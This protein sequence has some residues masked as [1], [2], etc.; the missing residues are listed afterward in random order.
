MIRNAPGQEIGVALLDV[1]GGYHCG[2][3]NV[4]VTVKKR[5]LAPESGQGALEMLHYGQFIY[6][7]TAGETDTDY[8]AVFFHGGKLIPQCVQC[9]TAPGTVEPP[10]AIGGKASISRVE[11]L[12]ITASE[13][14]FGS[15]GAWLSGLLQHDPIPLTPKIL[16]GLNRAYPRLFKLI[17][18]AP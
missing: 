4:L 9:Q 2:Q 7:P 14:V 8:L 17:E 6:Y 3:S 13:T 1:D 11:F 18:T 5:G 10:P 12:E 15:M 16:T